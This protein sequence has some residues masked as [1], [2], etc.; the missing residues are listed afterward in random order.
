MNWLKSLFLWGFITL[1]STSCFVDDINEAEENLSRNQT[2]INQY[3]QDNNLDAN[4]TETGLFYSIIENGSGQDAE[5]GR[6]LSARV[7][8]KLPSG[9]VFEDISLRRNEADVFKLLS[10]GFISKE[11]L[12]IPTG[13][14]E[15]LDLLRAGDSAVFVMPY[16]LGLGSQGNTVIPPYSVLI[17]EVK[18][19]NVRTEDDIIQE[20]IATEGLNPI[21]TSSGLYTEQTLAPDPSATAAQNG[22]TLGVTYVGTLLDGTEFDR[23]ADGTTFSFVLGNQSVIQGW[24][25]A[26]AMMKEGEKRTLIIPSSLAYGAEGSGSIIGPYETLVF[27]VEL[28][29]VQE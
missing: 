11:G 28:V 2:L 24:E 17:Y 29:S 19:E 27:E 5:V 3:L 4:E 16:T 1:L 21:R 26:F 10:G 9:S 12:L 7:V 14:S 8:G 18:L 25:E 22:N 6:E 20:Y 13:L 23:S 15:G